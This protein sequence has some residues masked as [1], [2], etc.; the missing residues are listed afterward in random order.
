MTRSQISPEMAARI[1]AEYTG[2]HGNTP[3][4]ANKYGVS[5][6][7]IQ[8]V[9]RNELCPDSAYTSR[10]DKRSGKRSDWRPI[11][12]FPGYEINSLGEIWGKAKNQRSRI[13]LS[14]AIYAEDGSAYGGKR[15]RLLLLAFVGPPPFEGAVARHLDDNPNHNDVLVN[16]SWGSPKDNHDDGVRN[17]RHAVRGSSEALRYG[18]HA[19]GK[20]RSLEVRRKISETK[21]NYA[22]RQYF[23]G[24]RDGLGHWRRKN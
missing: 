24:E 10:Y 8:R 2:K 16:L 22:E 17:N 23:G 9:I 14:P 12:G 4:L 1:R 21:R 3:H 19:L 18:K 20:P 6:S 5:V 11:P 15:S 13:L 7:S